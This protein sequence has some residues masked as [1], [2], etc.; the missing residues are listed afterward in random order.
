VRAARAARSQTNQ[1]FIATAVTGHL[2]ALLQTLKA[3]GLVKPDARPRPARLPF[4]RSAGTLDTLKAA[5][6]ETGVPACQLLGLC[7]AAASAPTKPDPPRRRGERRKRTDS[8]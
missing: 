7:L 5:S 6:E 8:A 3:I 1:Q 4:S 2:P